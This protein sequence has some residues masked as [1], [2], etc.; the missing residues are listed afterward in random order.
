[1]ALIIDL[2]KFVLI[3]LR[4]KFMNP[5]IL[6]V[7]IHFLPIREVFVQLQSYEM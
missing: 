4:Y 6:T 5:S 7:K 3:K 1:M 2:K